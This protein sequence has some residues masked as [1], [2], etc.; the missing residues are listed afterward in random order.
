M[1]TFSWQ[2]PTPT[3]VSHA[4]PYPPASLLDV[5]GVVRLLGPSALDP[6]SARALVQQAI[7]HGDPVLSDLAPSAGRP[8][9][10]LAI[11]VDRS[12]AIVL[13]I[14]PQRFL[15]PYLANW[16][17]KRATAESLLVRT[18]GP[19]LVYLSPRHN[20]PSAPIFARRNPPTVNPPIRDQ[21]N[22]GWNTTPTDYPG[23]PAI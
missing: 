17:G 16:P 14:D 5:N 23:V 4:S 3:L 1:A 15:Y 7:A 6:A 22:F 10:Y 9:M 21:V 20:L 11:P 2:P 13:E 8:L 19:A 12:G 18:E